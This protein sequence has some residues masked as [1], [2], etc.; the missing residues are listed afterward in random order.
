ME[1]MIVITSVLSKIALD[2]PEHIAKIQLFHAQL[3]YENQEIN[4]L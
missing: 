2:A 4:E 3:A 1:D